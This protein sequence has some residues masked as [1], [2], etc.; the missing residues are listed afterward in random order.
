MDT[1]RMKDIPA[2]DRPY[3]RCVRL[4]PAALN[5]EELLSIIIRTGSRGRNCLETA[6]QI[7][8]LS[9]PQDGIL[10]LSH[11]SLQQLKSVAGIGTVKAIQL[12][13]IGELSRRI[14]KRFAVSRIR[15]FHLP[16]EIVNYY[17]EDMRHMEQ[18][19]VYAMY[20]DRK[21]GLIKDMLIAK[22]TAT[23][24]VISPRDV[25]IEAVRC[26]ASGVILVHNHPSG[27]PTPSRQ[28]CLLTKRMQDAGNLLDIQ[29]LD[30]IVIGDNTYCS[31][32]R[33]GRL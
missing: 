22:G 28:D 8:A 4:G 7:L 17:M 30:H 18:E 14:S 26:R 11:L 16:E 21:H 13:C 2:I 6:R 23:T 25:F 33:E 29:L 27:D 15:S 5:D 10:G 24:A 20:L 3:E 32:K 19:H 12:L 9:Y 1:I 31:F